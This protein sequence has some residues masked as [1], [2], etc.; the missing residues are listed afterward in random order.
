MPEVP[1]PLISLERR[2]QVRRT[3]CSAHGYSG[4]EI[5]RGTGRELHCCCLAPTPG[6]IQRRRSGQFGSEIRRVPKLCLSVLLRISSTAMRKAAALYLLSTVAL[7]GQDLN[8]R[9][10]RIIQ[11]RVANHQFMGS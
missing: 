4:G 11:S 6:G 2:Q 10:E 1:V 7:V 9:F 8:P 3:C 5:V